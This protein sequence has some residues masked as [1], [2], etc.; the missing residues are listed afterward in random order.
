M[1]PNYKILIIDD[2]TI[3]Q[4]VTKQL[5]KKTL[6]ITDIST[7]NNGKEGIQWLNNHKKSFEESLII[8]L[9]IKMPEMDGFEFLSE[10]ETLPEELK[11]ETQI[12]MLSSTLDPNDIRRAKN[13]KYVKTLLSKP[14]PIKEFGEMIYPDSSPK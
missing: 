6:G 4:I 10:Y 7:T 8:L 5:L 14:L 2:N 9:D 11:K 1:K 3:D 13:N 12:F